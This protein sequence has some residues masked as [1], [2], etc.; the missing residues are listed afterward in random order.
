MKSDSGYMQRYL[1]EAGAQAD[2][3]LLQFFA[4]VDALHARPLPPGLLTPPDWSQLAPAP[5]ATF[6]GHRILD[7]LQRQWLVR[8]WGRPPAP[9]IPLRV[10]GLG[11]LVLLGL[12][13]SLLPGLVTAPG[14]AS[15]PVTTWQR[16]TRLAHYAQTS[17]DAINFSTT[18]AQRLAIPPHI[19]R[20][21]YISLVR[22]RQLLA[23]E[24]VLLGAPNRPLI[25]ALATR[26]PLGWSPTMKKAPNGQIYPYLIFIY[27]YTNPQPIP[28]SWER[29]ISDATL[30][31]FLTNV[32]DTAP[33]TIPAATP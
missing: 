19:Y 28:L 10:L 11:T 12:V 22:T 4:D 31:Q 32:G 26:G 25:V 17:L 5:V 6:P 15:A 29:T 2:P 9:A 24:N 33:C 14:P 30:Q 3:A 13:I 27:D 1:L 16:D 18:P 20:V 7:W 23:D 21:G 8:W